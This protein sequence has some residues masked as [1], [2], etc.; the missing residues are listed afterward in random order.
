M[1][2]ERF[3]LPRRRPRL[4]LSSETYEWSI[5][6]PDPDDPLVLTTFAEAAC[7]A[8]DVIDL[9]VE[10]EVV[11]MLDERRR[12]TA[13]LLDPPAEVGMFVGQA[14]LPG[15]EAPFCQT[16]VI[17]VEHAL[18]AGPPTTDQVAAFRAIRR[19]HMAQGLLLLDVV[20]TDGDQVTSVSIGSDPDPVWFDDVVTEP[21]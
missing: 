10:R 21:S 17:V 1:P 19:A 12:V 7:L 8:I 16:M 2:T 18:E 20:L 9:P 13:L 3:R 15:V 14:D 6:L 4:Q 11:V 5:F